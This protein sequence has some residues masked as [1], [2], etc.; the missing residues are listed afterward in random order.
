[1]DD[2]LL[3]P[4]CCAFLVCYLCA[5]ERIRSRLGKRSTQQRE[6]DG[7]EEVHGH[8]HPLNS[9]QERV[10][11]RILSEYGDHQQQMQ[12]LR[13]NAEPAGAVE[14]EEIW[15]IGTPAQ[16]WRIFQLLACWCQTVPATRIKQ[17]SWLPAIHAILW[18]D[19]NERILPCLLFITCTKWR[20]QWWCSGLFAHVLHMFFV[21]NDALASQEGAAFVSFQGPFSLSFF[22]YLV[23]SLPSNFHPW[24]FPYAWQ[25]FFQPKLPSFLCKL[26]LPIQ[27]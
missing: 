8:D 5:Q 22:N 1:M 10:R 15:S 12:A 25:C 14:T 6:E 9:G 24:C 13:S 11:K 17:V 4:T 18:Q 16:K 21:L 20:R 7:L 26:S 3:C 2:S 27:A 19:W 23:C